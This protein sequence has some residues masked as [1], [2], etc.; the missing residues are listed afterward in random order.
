MHAIAVYFS[1]Y[2]GF[3]CIKTFTTMYHPYLSKL[4]LEN[5]W[6]QY[7]KSYLNTMRKLSTFNYY[8]IKSLCIHLSLPIFVIL[9]KILNKN[10]KASFCLLCIFGLCTFVTEYRKEDIVHHWNLSHLTTAKRHIGPQSQKLT[11]I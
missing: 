6:S 8:R 1:F 2:R 9:F 7:S 5:L 11:Q 3:E 10:R 4:I